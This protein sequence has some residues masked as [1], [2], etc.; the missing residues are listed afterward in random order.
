MFQTMDRMLPQLEA[1]IATGND[2]YRGL[3]RIP[4]VATLSH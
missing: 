1:L 3:S 2:V 4:A